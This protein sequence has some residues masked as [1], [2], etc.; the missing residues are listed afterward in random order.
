MQSKAKHKLTSGENKI[1]ITV[2]EMP[3]YAGVDPFV[4]LIDRDGNDN[5][6]AL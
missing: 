3:A 2:P 5:I 1:T 6:K 4:K